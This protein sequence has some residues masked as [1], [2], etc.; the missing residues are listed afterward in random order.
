MLAGVQHGQ[1]AG[2]L[3]CMTILPCALMFVSYLLYIKKYRL[4]EE[5]YERICV[6]LQVREAQQ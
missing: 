4:D 2:L 1:T 3:L 5:E 6:E